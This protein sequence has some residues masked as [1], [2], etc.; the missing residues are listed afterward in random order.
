MVQF[1]GENH[2]FVRPVL[3]CWNL[4]IRDGHVMRWTDLT[5]IR[6]TIASRQH[7]PIVSYRLA[8]EKRL[9]MKGG[10]CLGESEIRLLPDD[11]L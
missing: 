1:S 11:S 3:M 8:R 5:G 6:L 9:F 2:F 4:D 10:F 7:P